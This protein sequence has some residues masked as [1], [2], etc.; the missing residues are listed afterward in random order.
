MGILKHK[1]GEGGFGECPLFKRDKGIREARPS[2]KIGG[3]ISVLGRRGGKGGCG[4][5]YDMKG[6]G[7]F[8]SAL[9]RGIGG[10][11]KARVTG[12]LSRDGNIRQITDCKGG[13]R[14]R[15]VI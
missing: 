13:G 15:D 9:K 3:K 4:V 8:R 14:D 11:A 1:G 7:P 2:A 12:C 6:R 10:G 5:A